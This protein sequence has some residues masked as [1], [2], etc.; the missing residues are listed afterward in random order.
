MIS[1]LGGGVPFTEM[2]SLVYVYEE[3]HRRFVLHCINS[4][5]KLE[6]SMFKDS[7]ST[8]VSQS[9]RKITRLLAYEH[10]EGTPFTMTKIV[11]VAI[12]LSFIGLISLL[13]LSDDFL[14]IISSDLILILFV[15]SLVGLSTLIVGFASYKYYS[16]CLAFL[17]EQS[18]KIKAVVADLNAEN[19]HGLQWEMGELGLWVRITRPDLQFFNEYPDDEDDEPED[20]NHEDHHGHADKGHHHHS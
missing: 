8:H 19:K 5:Q 12:I 15:S 3:G 17:Q 7:E 13:V 20:E 18:S 1:L 14:N 10:K 6:D 4:S 2:G 11:Y 9:L 16:H